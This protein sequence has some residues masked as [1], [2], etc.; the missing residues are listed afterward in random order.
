MESDVVCLHILYP[1]MRDIYD[2]AK[3]EFLAVPGRI[4]RFRHL[5]E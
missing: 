2:G 4:N 1:L 3:H 5:L